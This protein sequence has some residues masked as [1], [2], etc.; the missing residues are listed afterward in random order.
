MKRNLIVV[1]VIMALYAAAVNVFVR[2]VSSSMERSFTS[3]FGASGYL[4]NAPLYYRDYKNPCCKKKKRKR[5]YKK[6][7]NCSHYHRKPSRDAK[8]TRCCYN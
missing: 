6:H 2:G 8:C 1:A 4:T 3:K 7:R 5:N